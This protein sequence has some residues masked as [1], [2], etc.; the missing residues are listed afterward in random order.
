MEEYKIKST[1]Q[2]SAECEEIILRETTKTRFVFK[3]LLVHN[4][5][6]EEASLKGTFVFQK[7]LPSQKW[8]D[9]KDLN[10]SELISG[11]YVKL[12]LKST[13]LL[14][15]IQELLGLYEIYKNDGIPRG[16][17]RYIKAHGSLTNLS[18]V[19]EEDLQQ[20]FELNKKAGINIFSKLLNYV[21][22]MENSQL[23]ADRLEKLEINSLQK[24]NTLIGIS[25]IKKIIENWR[26]NA[27][28]SDEEYWQ[29][30]FLK[31]PLILSQ[32]F[33]YPIILIKDK[34]YLGGKTFENK[35]GNLIDFL[36]RNDLTQNAVLIEIKTPTTSLL[37]SQYRS[38]VYNI[39]QELSGSVQQVLNYRRS[40]SMAYY[41]L[42][43][44][45]ILETFHPQSVVI[46][47]S[48]K[49]ELNDTEK[50]KSFEL[51]RNGLKDMMNC[52]IS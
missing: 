7:K 50:R 8:E 3:P 19:K 42:K 26:I 28:N 32:I 48:I 4:S 41:N 22:N 24:L 31:N 5:K 40:L 21:T 51:F 37:S 27:L 9:Q 11:Q 39:S 46:I 52:S 44:D 1:S 25:N 23:V 33:P 13:E 10:L 14:K 34:A 18:R 45:E 35:R 2:N 36:C 30:E 6:D 49:A 15:L 20:F 47:G 43:C 38:D 29:N 12:E 17:T 16:Q